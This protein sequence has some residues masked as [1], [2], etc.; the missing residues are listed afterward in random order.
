M[1]KLFILS[2]WAIFSVI[3]YAQVNC[4]QYV[5]PMIGTDFTG[6]TYPGAILPFGGVQV[7]PDTKLDGWEGCSGYH[8]AESTVYGFSHSHLSGTGCSDYGDV[9]LMPFVGKGS[10][11]NT[12]YCSPFSHNNE[13]AAPGYY[14]VLLDKSNV[15]VEL[16]TSTRVAMHKYTF[17]KTMNLRGLLLI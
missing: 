15:K 10:V 17:L 13:F 16:T 2:F 5:N 14:R 7:S 3:S 6:H 9:L 12:E 1:K 4:T 8:Y 11:I